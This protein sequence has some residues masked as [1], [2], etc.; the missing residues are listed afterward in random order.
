MSNGGVE[1]GTKFEGMGG[2][3]Y[4]ARNYKTLLDALEESLRLSSYVVFPGKGSNDKVHGPLELKEPCQC[5]LREEENGSY[6]AAWYNVRLTDSAQGDGRTEAGRSEAGDEGSSADR[7]RRPDE[8]DVRLEGG[9]AIRLFVEERG[10]TRWLVHH[11]YDLDHGMPP[12]DFWPK[13]GESGPLF[14]GAHQP[15]WFLDDCLFDV[16][17]QNINA[18]DFSPRPVETWIEVRPWGAGENRPVYYF[19]DTHYRPNL[20]VPV[21][22]CTVPKLPETPPEDKDGAGKPASAEISVWCKMTRTAPSATHR[23]GSGATQFLLH[24]AE[25]ENPSK[26][27]VMFQVEPKFEPSRDDASVGQF[28]VTV[29]ETHPVGSDPK[30]V[31]VEMDHRPDVIEHI[32]YPHAGS[33]EWRIRHVFT[34]RQALGDRVD[35]YKIRLTAFEKLEHGA[36]KT[37]EER[38]LKVRIPPKDRGSG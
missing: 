6:V 20:P 9:E 35:D 16:S 31:K 4:L 18:D 38:P 32:Y 25:A 27:K 34:Y 1:N 14:I 22:T 7:P 37:R 12:E 11:R 24:D 2:R 15:S 21:V 3:F 28:Q 10:G 5:K 13:R 23:V 36:I 30:P 29:K 17:F 8:A 19:Y 33:N 26:A